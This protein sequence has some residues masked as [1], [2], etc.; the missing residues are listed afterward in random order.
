MWLQGGK[1]DK[2][3][4]IGVSTEVLSRYRQAQ[5]LPTNTKGLVKVAQTLTGLKHARSVS[6]GS[7][8]DV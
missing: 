1:R 2:S 4:D 8:Q 5:P 7:E 6:T 3:R